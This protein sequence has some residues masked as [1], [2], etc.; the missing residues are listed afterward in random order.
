MR[1][2]ASGTERRAEIWASGL[3]R[4]TH[5]STRPC[6]TR[7]PRLSS[8]KCTASSSS[9]SSIL[10]GAA[11]PAA[12]PETDD[13]P[14]ARLFA[15][16]AMTS[17]VNA[18][19]PPATVAPAPPVVAA[20]PP[21]P[22]VVVEAAV[23][24]GTRPCEDGDGGRA[25]SHSCV[26]R[27]ARGTSSM[28]RKSRHD[29]ER[30]VAVGSDELYGG[31]TGSRDM[32]SACLSACS[33]CVYFCVFVCVRPLRLPFCLRLG[34]ECVRPCLPLRTTALRCALQSERGSAACVRGTL[35][36]GLRKGR[37][38]GGRG[39]EETVARGGVVAAERRQRRLKLGCAWR[40][41]LMAGEL[42]ELASSLT[43]V[44][45][46]R[47]CVLRTLG[48]LHPT[49]F[50]ARSII[51]TTYHVFILCFSPPTF[52]ANGVTKRS[53]YSTTG[54]TLNMCRRRQAPL[55]HC[56][57]VNCYSRMSSRDSLGRDVTSRH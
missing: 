28:R 48:A 31:M 7:Y 43:V 41:H 3:P 25:K 38:A 50:Q 46:G 26:T 42:L 14:P 35:G 32:A 29:V 4:D 52:S 27:Y 12:G 24:S 8:R 11:A 57:F 20:A 18:D 37:G 17:F 36:V 2:Q 56:L 47:R 19:S 1:N 21:P 33:P 39:G 45:V 5:R 16:V 10:R 9:S 13:E 15:A 23:A 49:S 51:G 22:P 30:K 55:W 34:G 40:W 53:D 44:L 6:P 54:T